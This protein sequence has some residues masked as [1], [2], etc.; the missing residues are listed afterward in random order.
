MAKMEWT[1]EQKKVID[2]RNRNIL[3]SAAA[4]SGKTA[5]LVERIITMITDEENPVDIDQLLI[6][7]FTKAAA[8]EMK[9]RIGNRIEKKLLEMPDNA[10]LQKQIA[11]IQNAE[12]TTTHSFCLNIIRNHFNSINLDPSFRVADE[13]EIKLLKSD[14]ISNLLEA[15][16]EE[17]TKEFINFIECYSSGKSDEQIEELILNLYNF[18]MSYPWPKDWLEENRKH[19]AIASL[20]E[21][22]QTEWMKS[23]LDYLRLI[24]Q[25]ILERNEEALRICLEPDGPIHYQEALL[26]DRELLE[27]LANQNSYVAYEQVLTSIQYKRLS[28]KKMPEVSEQK[29]ESVKS[30]REDMKKAIGDTVKNYFFQSPEEM[31][32]DMNQVQNV[33]NVLI[34]LTIQFMDDFAKEKEEKN[35]VDFNDLEHFALNILVHKDGDQISPSEVAQELSDHYVEI[36]VDE[37]QDSNY[38]QETI[39]NSI[40]KERYSNPNIF[41]VGDVK[42]SIYKFR[43]A[44]PELFMDKYNTYTVGDSSYQ[45]IDL[46]KNF[47]SRSNVLESANFIF[48]Q[49]MTRNLGNIEYNDEVALYP[50]ASFKE[51]ISEDNLEED[52]RDSRSFEKEITSQTTELILISEEDN[53]EEENDLEEINQKEMEARAIAARIREITDDKNGLYVLGKD[54][55]YRRAKYSDIVILLRTMSNWAD[56]FVDTL[57]A[58]GIPAYSDTQSGYFSAIEIKTILNLLKIIDNP[59]QEIPLAAVLHSPMY[60]FNSEELAVICSNRKKTDLYDALEIYS[61]HGSDEALSAKAAA[62]FE[63]L[64]KFRNM[65]PYTSVHKLILTILS[66]TNYYYYVTAMPAGDRRSANIDMLVQKAIEFEKTSY[67]G[68]FHFIRYIEKLNKYDIDFGEAKT[69]GE[70]D[71]TVRI[72]S[73]HKSKGLEFPVV[74][75]SGLGKSF[76]NQ[77]ARSKIVLH[78]DLGL[79]PDYI[80]YELRMKSPTLMKKVIQKKMQLEN[81]SEELRILYVALTRAKEKLILTGT[82]KKLIDKIK[83]YSNIIH[84]EKK[85]QLFHDLSSASNYLDWIIPALLRHRGFEEILKDNE[86]QGTPSGIY[87]NHISKFKVKIV[88]YF[89]LTST[90][91]MK[92]IAGDVQKRELLSWDS[93]KDCDE[94]VKNEIVKRLEYQYPYAKEKD[95][96]AKITVS[97]LKRLGQMIDEDYSEKLY[98]EPSIEKYKEENYSEEKQQSQQEMTLEEMNSEEKQS[99]VSIL[100][101]IIPR[102]IQPEKEITATSRG[103]IYHKVLECIDLLSIQSPADVEKELERLLSEGILTETDTRVVRVHQIYRFTQ[104]DL[105]NRMRKAKSNGKL[106][107]E[108]QFVLGALAKEVYPD[109]DSEETVL[110]QGIIDAYF[111]EEDG[112]VLMDYKTDYVVK[113]KEETLVQKYKVQLNYYQKAIEQITNKKVKEKLIYSFSLDKTISIL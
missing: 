75:V 63:Q 34:D 106:F 31:L 37:Y 96:K 50:G 109:T 27:S 39:I 64:E 60:E 69:I 111:E 105:A 18:S 28:T 67:H 12:I 74:F 3:V 48:E 24:F 56:V 44:R 21:M 53:G 15:H 2:L 33:M 113:G 90:E 72:M 54:N 29:K 108:K 89:S 49:I 61:I 13:A 91:V 19:F 98:E 78:P 86:L 6:V 85:E 5:V 99:E 23:L 101:E 20:E 103:T 70:N 68:L 58:E 94:T 59:R 82:Q 47:R 83:K 38:V 51:Y 102:F 11:L 100:E 84:Q 42:Q 1:A 93:E 66:E 77:D 7:T 76:N 26:S 40:S 35:L 110:I 25:D 55:T 43:L 92:Q 87:Y 36:L 32:S 97:E 8:A 80:D 17:P 22:E 52:I 104:S 46:H 73:I 112:I 14:V 81:L 62:F 65:V 4:G 88:D 30:I 107:L 41:M 57:M 95:I 16:Y 71:D 45:R 79:G 9:E 10:H